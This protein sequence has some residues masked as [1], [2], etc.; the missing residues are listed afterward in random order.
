MTSLDRQRKGTRAAP[1]RLV[2]NF[3]AQAEED[4]YAID[5]EE[6]VDDDNF[7]YPALDGLD[8]DQRIDVLAFM[9]AKGFTPA[10]R[11]AGRRLQRR[12]GGR[13]HPS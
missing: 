4:G 9:R 8:G 7:V 2:D 3:N 12:P 5:G 1:I 10:G 13:G 11:S 6:E